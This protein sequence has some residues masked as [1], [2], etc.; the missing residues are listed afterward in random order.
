MDVERKRCE[1]CWGMVP[2]DAVE[3]PICSHPFPLGSGHIDP[4]SPEGKRRKLAS[5]PERNTIWPRSKSIWF[6]FSV[7]FLLSFI[8]IAVFMK[9]ENL[10]FAGSGDGNALLGDFLWLALGAGIIATCFMVIDYLDR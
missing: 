9:L 6:K 4:L 7:L 1:N 3:C 2:A 5:A 8:A 10:Q